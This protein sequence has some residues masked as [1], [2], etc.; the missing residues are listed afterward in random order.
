[1]LPILCHN[2]CIS[3]LLFVRL[4]AISSTYA[5]DKRELWKL[6]T[7]AEGERYARD[8]RNKVNNTCRPRRRDGPRRRHMQRRKLPALCF[9]LSKRRPENAKPV[10][11]YAYEYKSPDLYPGLPFLPRNCATTSVTHLRPTG[12]L[13]FRDYPF[14]SSTEFN[15][16]YIYLVAYNDNEYIRACALEI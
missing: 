5:Q 13:L 12:F 9:K 14:S 2:T 3:Y 16:W 8:V 15:S 4:L 7:R 6:C 10:C 11:A 1:M